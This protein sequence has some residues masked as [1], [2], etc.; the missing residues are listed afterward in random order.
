[1]E[2]KYVINA[3]VF[4]VI[5]LVVLALSFLVFDR[6]TPGELW[7]HIVE[8]KNVALAITVGAFTLAMAQIIAAAVHG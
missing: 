5:G 1:M 2:F 6:L 4:S 3:L 8:E 7:K